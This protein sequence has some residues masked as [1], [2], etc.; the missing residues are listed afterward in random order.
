MPDATEEAIPDPSTQEMEEKWLRYWEEEGI[1]RFDPAD[2]RPV[3]SIDTPP[4]TV[5]GRMHI[6]HAYSYN[7]MD[8][9]ARYQRMRG[10]SMFYP[11]GFD[12]NGLPTERYTE[13]AVGKKLSDVGRQEFIRLCLQETKKAEELMERSWRRIGTSCDWTLAYRTIDKPVIRVSQ[14]SFLDLYRQGRA[15]RAERPTIWCPECQTAIAQVEIEDRVLPSTF[16]DIAFDLVSGVHDRGTKLAQ[17]STVPGPEANS[18]PREV[19]SYQQGAEGKIVISTTRPEL[20]PACVA[21]FVHPDDPRTRHLHG[22]QVRVPVSGAIVPVLTSDKVDKETGTGVV[23]NCTFGDQVDI[24]WWQE[25]HLP[26]RVVISPSG[27]MTEAAGK[28]VG[29]SVHHARGNILADLDREGRLLHQKQIEHTVNVHE[30]CGTP[31]EFLVTK[32]WFV[33]YLDLKDELLARGH[34]VKWHPEYMRVRYD[35]WVKGLKWDWCISRQR[36]F[37]VPF[38]VWYCEACGEPKLAAT[39]EL[40]VDPT[41]DKP[42]GKCAKCENA[43]FRGETDVMDTWATSSLTPQIAILA[44]A[45]RMGV[46]DARLADLNGDPRLARMLPMSVR[47][48]AHEIISFWAFNTIVKAQLH[49]D[50]VPWKDAQISGFVKL[51]KGKKMSK[52]KGDIV[53]PLDVIAEHSGDALRYWSATGANLGEDII[54]NP[55]DLTRAQRLVTKLRN[56]EALILRGTDRKPEPAAHQ[57]VMDRWILAEFARLVEGATRDWDAYDYTKA[58]KDAEHFAWNTF[59][60]H[61][62]EAAKQRLYAGDPSARHTAYVV[63]L[64]LLKLLAPVLVFSTEDLY[65]AHY[66]RFEGDRSIHVAAWPEARPPADAERALAEGALVRD[67]IAA[68]RNWKSQSKLAL[69]QPMPALEVVA[70][71]SARAAL[72]AGKG[73][74]VSTVKAA[75]L[76]FVEAADVEMRPTGVEPVHAKIG[77]KYRGDARAIADALKAMDAAKVGGRG[78]T[79]RLPDGRSIDLAPDDYEVR[80]SP[81]LH[82]TAVDALSVGGVTVLVRRG[83]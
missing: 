56:I 4:P 33:K 78:V 34:Q 74:V 73:D 12:D 59:A 76:R 46:K 14:E 72:Q 1:Y 44:A 82:G 32:Q 83:A 19:V 28:Y 53:E 50:K 63:G 43:V 16:N 38:P 23:M 48:Q 2:P 49:H 15:Y 57:P 40:P 36:Y 65:Q 66:R 62:L 54:W 9:V 3:F 68:V 22:Q 6:G 64:G 69:N 27:T 7:Q 81:T 25:N 70:D 52:S 35:N 24:E 37:G 67:V 26:L 11:F 75:D 20:I 47:P 58:I 8:F 29:Q 18:K 39:D 42:R 41:V 45:D 13:K 5:S 31:I 17:R 51:G 10:R 61:Y 21:I 80:S 79:V 30:R 77:P 55:K 71:A 60:D